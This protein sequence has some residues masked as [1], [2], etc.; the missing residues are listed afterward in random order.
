MT[1][2]TF[3]TIALWV[4]FLIFTILGLMLSVS[5]LRY[6]G[7]G[8]SWGLLLGLMMLVFPALGVLGWAWFVR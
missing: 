5:A 3:V 6:R 2:V 8:W 1:Y 4:Q 7:Q